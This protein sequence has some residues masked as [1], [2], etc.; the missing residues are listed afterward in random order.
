M[1]N[2]IKTSR[3]RPSGTRH[4]ALTIRI[5]APLL[6]WID[7]KAAAYGTHRSGMVWRLIEESSLGVPLH[8]RTIRTAYHEAGH[9]VV[10]RV[11]GVA[12]DR[13]TIEADEERLGSVRHASPHDVY[14]KRRDDRPEHGY[15]SSIMI[16]LAGRAAEITLLD[17]HR[18]DAGDRSDRRRIN[19]D[20]RI[21]SKPEWQTVSRRGP[22]PVNDALKRELKV[23]TENLV[24]VKMRRSIKGVAE[25]LLR[26]QTIGQAEIDRIINKSGELPEARHFVAER[27]QS[28]GLVQR[29]RRPKNAPRRRT[30]D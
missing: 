5:P 4:P 29:S 3:K 8:L 28:L 30:T 2:V 25:A 24:G 7:A 9:A 17:I 11:L 22:R 14:G 13:M 16:N 21:V 10:A 15:Y 23:M 6:A 1:G 12:V 18:R 20:I 27:W 26:S 19:K